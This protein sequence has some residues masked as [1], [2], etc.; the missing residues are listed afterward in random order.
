MLGMCDIQLGTIR[1]V[2]KRQIKLSYLNYLNN[3]I[4]PMQYEKKNLSVFSSL[5][6]PNTGK[7]D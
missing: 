3:T 2:F 6:F 1:P 4:L 7:E 5:T